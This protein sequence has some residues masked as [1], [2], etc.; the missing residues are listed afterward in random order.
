ML[1]GRNSRS[2]V[3]FVTLGIPLTLVV[4]LVATTAHY[5]LSWENLTNL[6]GQ[7]TALLI[8]SFGQLLVALVAGLDASTRS[9]SDVASVRDALAKTGPLAASLDEIF[10]ST[11]VND[12]AD[13]LTPKRLELLSHGAACMRKIADFSK[14]V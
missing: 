9:L 7:M 12:P 13:P 14:L 5:F 10:V 11:L 1:L 8:V 4:L 6:S 3:S 2:G